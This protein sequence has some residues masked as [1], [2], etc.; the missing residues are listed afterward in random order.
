MGW[1]DGPSWLEQRRK[2][3]VAHNEVLE[4][5]YT[6]PI[7][8]YGLYHLMRDADL[9]S[10]AAQEDLQPL[11]A[12]AAHRLTLDE[13]DLRI[14]LPMQFEPLTD[15]EHDTLTYVIARAIDE[16]LRDLPRA[17][18]PLRLAE[19]MGINATL[20]RHIED[21]A[22]FTH[23]LRLSQVLSK[24]VQCCGTPIEFRR[25]DQSVN[26]QE[27]DFFIVTDLKQARRR[28]LKEFLLER[29]LEP[30][31]V[32]QIIDVWPHEYLR[33]ERFS[34]QVAYSKEW[35]FQRPY[36]ALPQKPNQAV[37]HRREGSLYRLDARYENA[38]T[39]FIELYQQHQADQSPDPS[40]YQPTGPTT[41]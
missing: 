8:G 17:D 16:L 20:E 30:G 18:E 1:L 35:F 41:E 40:Q 11:V 3:E 14:Q 36:R 33:V 27:G 5:F 22:S 6:D 21:T 26:A 2:Q 12:N 24:L 10:E 15:V 34:K 29:D 31:A 38:V 7:A 28:F 37:V 23:E 39:R 13:D 9:L 19:L 25:P 32:L 4:A